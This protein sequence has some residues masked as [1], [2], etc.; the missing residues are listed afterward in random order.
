MILVMNPEKVAVLMEM[1]F[2]PCGTRQIDKKDVCQ[3]VATDELL[4]ILN[5]KSKFSVKDYVRDMKLTF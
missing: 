5:D 4:N 1:G 2:T 3:F